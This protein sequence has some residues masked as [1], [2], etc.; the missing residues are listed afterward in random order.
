MRFGPAF[1]AT[2]LFVAAW[3]GVMRAPDASADE[4]TLG[5]VELGRL[6][7][8]DRTLSEP[9]GTSCASCHDPARAFSGDHGSGMGVPAGS[10]P[11]VLAR[12]ATPSLL[13]LRYVP[14]F[15]FFSDDS[16]NHAI[17]YA[18]HGGFFWDGRADSI[19]ELVRQ[20]L[21]NPREMNNKDAAMIADKLR[22][23]P[24]A[25]AFQREFPAA[26]DG[27]DSAVTALGLAL[28]AFLLSPP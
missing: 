12:R 4:G 25:D 2:V 17:D 27:D 28:Q 10:R 26:L 13:Y 6:I 5:R 16:D 23:A 24:Y 14:R 20:P 21:L 11:G 18:P 8:F 15:R 7:F 9:H 3:L 19:A 1:A 22:H